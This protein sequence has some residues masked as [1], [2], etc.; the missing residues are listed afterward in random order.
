VL[1]KPTSGIGAPSARQFVFA[2]PPLVLLHHQLHGLG[3][4]DVMV[5]VRVLQRTDHH[6][7]EARLA[8]AAIRQRRADAGRERLRHGGRLGRPAAVGP[9][10]RGDDGKD[11]EE[12]D[13]AVSHH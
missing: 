12:E 13:G 4:L 5:G 9:A 8:G 10:G 3:V 2:R 6:R 1:L 7:E 11:G